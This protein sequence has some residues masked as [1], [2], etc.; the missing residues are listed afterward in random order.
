MKV[1]VRHHVFLRSV[2][3]GAIYKSGNT[4]KYEE[5]GL[6]PTDRTAPGDLTAPDPADPLG[7]KLVMDTVC[8]SCIQDSSLDESSCSGDYVLHQAEK[9]KFLTDANSSRPIR[10][11][12]TRRLLPLA[13]NQFGRRG[14]HFQAFLEEMADFVV[15]RP[16]GCRLL[17]GTFALSEFAA[18]SWILRRWGSRITWTIERACA[19][20]TSTAMAAMNFFNT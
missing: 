12:P 2:P 10:L 17:Q 19:A 1:A 7:R 6:R 8:T 9:G 14:W 20:N 3:A 4:V 16:S 11:D 5:R 15:G 18:A 13:A